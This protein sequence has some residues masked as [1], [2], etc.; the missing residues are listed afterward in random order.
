MK[1]IREIDKMK[2][3]SKIMRKENKLVGFVPTMG[4]FHEGHLN[5]IRAAR[6]Q[7]DIVIVSVF[8][9]PIQFMPNEDFEK[10]PRDISRDEE[11]AKS[12]GV[13]VIFYPKK[14]DMYP[15][16]YSTYIEVEKLTDNL[17][18]KSRPGHFRGVTTVVA[19]LFEIVRPDIAYFGQKDA[20][21]AFV[22]RKMVED[23]SMGVVIKIMP[24]IR[25][26]NGLAMSSRN[27]YLSKSERKDA[28]VLYHALSQA[29]ELIRS[30][31]KDAKKIIKKIRNL[32]NEKPSA[33]IDY[34]SIA[35]T[36]ALKDVKSVKEEALIAL[37]VFIGKTRLI[38]NIIINPKELEASRETAEKAK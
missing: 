28:S 36:K 8:V 25:E 5:L 21:Q 15:H 11:L 32:V 26:E 35:D 19:K 18:G 9:N 31:E 23:L 34:V 20:Q 1:V 30:G 22:V 13:D 7:V 24:I 16:G 14:E 33:K 2:T 37:A 4:Y 38:D 6:K 17:C 3:H 29:E 12:C 10:Y 27:V